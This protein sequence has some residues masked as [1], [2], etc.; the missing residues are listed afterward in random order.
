MDPAK[1]ILLAMIKWAHVNRRN[2]VDHDV[3]QSEN[4]SVFLDGVRALLVTHCFSHR[5]R[6]RTW[7]NLF[8]CDQRNTSCSTCPLLFA[9]P[10]S[11]PLSLPLFFAFASHE[12]VNFHLF[13]VVPVRSVVFTLDASLSHLTSES[14]VP[15]QPRRVRLRHSGSC[16][17]CQCCSFDRVLKRV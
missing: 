7:G 2:T 14:I 16:G 8:G 15:L 1:P 10:F 9:L 4:P 11:L 5:G 12:R 3:I 6:P 17:S 13:G